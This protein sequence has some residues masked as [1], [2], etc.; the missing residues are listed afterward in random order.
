M[1]NCAPFGSRNPP[2]GDE[3]DWGPFYSNFDLVRDSP[4]P[5]PDGA[6][7]DRDPVF[8]GHMDTGFTDSPHLDD[9]CLEIG[10]SKNFVEWNQPPSDARTPIE[11]LPVHGEGSGKNMQNHGTATLSVVI[12]TNGIVPA[13]PTVKMI[14]YRVAVAPIMHAEQMNNLG[15]AIGHFVE[16]VERSLGQ[17]PPHVVSMSLGN[18][19]TGDV[20]GLRGSTWPAFSGKSLMKTMIRDYAKRGVIF[21]AASG[22][23]SE[24]MGDWFLTKFGPERLK[25]LQEA[26]KRTNVPFPASMR[27]VISAGAIDRDSVPNPLGFYDGEI[28]TMAPGVHIRMSRAYRTAANQ[29][30]ARLDAST[31]SSYSTQFTAAAAAL[32]I[33]HHGKERLTHE[34]GLDLI[35]EAF[36]FCLAESG[37]APNP[38]HLDRTNAPRLNVDCLLKFDL[39]SKSEVKA[40]VP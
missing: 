18:R 31:G 1:P 40:S 37:D 11:S 13:A 36:R 6:P 16:S 3:D 21:V 7:A 32:W 26:L 5:R 14:P 39:P 20:L 22:Q 12:G 4:P 33:E 15:N 9:S 38:D 23:I 8:I 25:N 30:D 17:S 29:L 10:E 27:E 24:E 19:V 28:D 2:S 35:T 34:F